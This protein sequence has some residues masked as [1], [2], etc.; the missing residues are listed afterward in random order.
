[1]LG[2]YEMDEA[3]P[4]SPVMQ[5]HQRFK[6]LLKKKEFADTM[7]LALMQHPRFK[8]TGDGIFEIADRKLEVHQ[9]MCEFVT[10]ARKKY[11]MCQWAWNRKE[12]DQYQLFEEST[13]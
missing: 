12:F 9:A 10:A 5:A 3:K 11:P 7:L 1:M 4:Q 6:E 8:E 13:K 2:A